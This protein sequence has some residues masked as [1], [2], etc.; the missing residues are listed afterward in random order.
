MR[1]CKICNLGEI[2]YDNDTCEY[3]QWEA[4]TIQETN[5]NYVGGANN[6]TFNQYLQFWKENKSNILSK[7]DRFYTL[8]KS[9]EYYKDNFLS[10]NQEILKRVESGEIKQEIK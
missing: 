6:M 3:C 2:K 9:I 4:D 1:K 7:S 5:P 10:I 8:N